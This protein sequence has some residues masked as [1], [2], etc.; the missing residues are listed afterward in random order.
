M[1][2][3]EPCE[4]LRRVCLLSALPERFTVCA[5]WGLRGVERL[6]PSV[7]GHRRKNAAGR[8]LSSKETPASLRALAS[9]FA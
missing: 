5:G 1:N 8:S 4:K 9:P 2:R 7:D 6:A 3:S